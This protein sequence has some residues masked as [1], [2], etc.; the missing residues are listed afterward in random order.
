VKN[1][2]IRNDAEGVI[3]NSIFKDISNNAKNMNKIIYF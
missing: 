3:P 1:W 2:T